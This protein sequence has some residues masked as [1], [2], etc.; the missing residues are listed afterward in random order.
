MKKIFY[1]IIL[2]F[3]C[4]FPARA[5]D[6]LKTFIIKTNSQNNSE[7]EFV[8]RVPSGFNSESAEKNSGR[9][10]V[11]FG[12]RNWKGEKTIP[13]YGFAELADRYSLFLISPSFKDDKY[14]YP[15]KWSGKALL[16]AIEKVRN[17]YGLDRNNKLFYYGYSAGGQC[18]NLF[19]FWKPEIVEAWGAH[20]CGVWPQKS[21][22]RK[23]NFKGRTKENQVSFSPGIVTC[24]EKDVERYHLTLRFAQEARRRGIDILWKSYPSGHGL[25]NRELSLAKVFFES[26]LLNPDKKIKFIGDD[27][28]MQYYPID[29]KAAENI[30]I[31]DRS[32]FFNEK[33]AELWNSHT[34]D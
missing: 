4:S 10:F 9:I 14:W 18:A 6:N 17:D 1:C 11:L 30:E 22:F 34:T 25:N 21:W 13:R 3:I 32:V 2:F 24:G 15:E 26:V 31:E 20:A 5:A 12:G 33:T 29:S 23:S 8:L 19:Y 16:Q 7:L 27:Q 28:L